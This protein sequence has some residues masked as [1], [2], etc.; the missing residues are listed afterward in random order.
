MSRRWWAFAALALCACGPSTRVPILLPPD[1][2]PARSGGAFL[3]AHLHSGE[4]VLLGNWTPP[5]PGATLLEG[6]GGRFDAQRHLVSTGHWALP[7]DSIALLESNDQRTVGRLGMTGMV[8][9][10][11]L[12]GFVTAM[13]MADPKSCFGSCPTFYTEEGGGE[14][15]RAE[16][17]SASIARA[18]E[19]TDV[20]ALP[21]VRPRDGMLTLIMRNEAPET[22][23]VDRVRIL[24]ARR[25]LDGSVLA[26][27]GG[28][29]LSA[30]P[31]VAPSACAAQGRDCLAAVRG[32]DGSEYASLADSADLAA[33][34]IIE[35]EFPETAGD[36]GVVVQARH[37]L[38]STF[39]FYQTIAWLGSSA[40][41]WLAALERGGP[42][43]AERAMGLAR[44]LGGIEVLVPDGAG[45]WSVAGAFDETGPIAPDRQVIALPRADGGPVRVRLRVARGHYRIGGVALVA[46]RG[47]APV[48]A[49]D[50]VRVD[51]PDGEDPAAL[52]SLL[53]PERHLV[54]QRGDALRITF[55]LTALDGDHEL[56]LESRG[57]YYEW[58]R[59]EWSGEENAA[60]AA[61]VFTDPAAA[62]RRM[63]PLF[64]AKEGT[65]ESAF[66]SSR[67]RGTLP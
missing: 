36:L 3:K 38:L 15:L 56:F 66:W 32:D 37:T 9:W 54:T 21:G 57:F 53:E 41:D 4:V 16:G 64:K 46:L 2:A 8:V 35:L 34:E 65:M 62:L 26:A 24:A 17:F 12:T 20:D 59:P 11:S 28:R 52:A 14:T 44:E 27:P 45:G 29:F 13:C 42:D 60:L 51:G 7:F 33:R 55:D 25:P 10:S 19:A 58:M 63:A 22:H 39:L 50:P 67:F 30:G 61:L 43:V 18:L 40:G 48:R 31:R 5:P 6:D 23:A 49:F 1:A 47:E